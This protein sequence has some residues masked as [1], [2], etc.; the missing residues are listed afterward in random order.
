MLNTVTEQ[1]Y[2]DLMQKL[3]NPKKIEKKAHGGLIDTPL[4][5]GSRYI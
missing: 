3:K 5:G 2:L 1:E 4:T